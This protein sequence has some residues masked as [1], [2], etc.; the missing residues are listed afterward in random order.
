MSELI[1]VLEA[2]ELLSASPI[3]APHRVSPTIAAD[4]AAIVTARTTIV[5]DQANGRAG[6]VADR[7]NIT[8]VRKTDQ[9]T[10]KADQIKLRQDAGN[11]IAVQSDRG[12]LLIDEAKLRSDHNDAITKL[13][14]DQAAGKTLLATDRDALKAAQTKLRDDRIAGA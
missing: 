13:K 6:L 3:K 12:Q 14:Q 4:Q 11:S 7:A 2:R 8:T 5:Q 10:I 9:A 1:E